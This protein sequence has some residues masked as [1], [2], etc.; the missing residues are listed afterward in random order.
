MY[1]LVLSG[2]DVRGL[3]EMQAVIGAVGQAFR[4]MG[5]RP[6]PRCRPR[7]TSFWTKANSGPCPRLCRDAVGI[8]WV[9]VH[10][11]TP[12]GACPPSWAC[13]IYNDPDTGYPLAMMDAT[14]SPPTARAHAAAIASKYLAR[15]DSGHAG[16]H[17]RRPPGPCA[18]CKAHAELF[19]SQTDKGFRRFPEAV[20]E[21]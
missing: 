8:K 3:L 17:R 20:V 5:W 6:E 12:P 9:N 7:P 10:P 4:E 1:A 21:K 18:D 11:R 13:F 15:P 2:S 19:R 14:E 16:N